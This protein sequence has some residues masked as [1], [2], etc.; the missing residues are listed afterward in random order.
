MT[1]PFGLL[2]L[3]LLFNMSAIEPEEHTGSE[4]NRASKQQHNDARKQ[5][6]EEQIQQAAEQKR[7]VDAAELQ[8]EL[9]A[10]RRVPSEQGSEDSGLDCEVCVGCTEA[11]LE[12]GLETEHE[13]YNCSC[14]L[15]A[16]KHR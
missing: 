15:E 9:E 1:N 13:T 11:E 2:A 4:D 5:Q 6:L 12:L 8:S 7:Y 14:H 3:Q 10:L 16:M